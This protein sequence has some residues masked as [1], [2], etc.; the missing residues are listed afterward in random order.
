M[1][2]RVNSLVHPAIEN[3]SG[4]GTGH[5]SRSIVDDYLLSTSDGC[6]PGL[7]WKARVCIA[8][9]RSSSV[10]TSYPMRAFVLMSLSIV[11]PW[12]LYTDGG[13]ALGAS[14]VH[15]PDIRGSCR[16]IM[17]NSSGAALIYKRGSGDRFAVF[18]PHRR[19]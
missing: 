7:G 8:G 10:L 1:E 13:D 6:P 19:G 14:T 9:E 11:T 2:G 4:T 5:S 16:R 12:L 18:L 15:Q 3:A 17:H